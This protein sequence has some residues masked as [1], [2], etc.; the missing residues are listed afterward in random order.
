MFW[1]AMV[2]G[3][4]VSVGSSIGTMSFVILFTGWKCLTETK[5]AKRFNEL[6]ELSCAAL[7]KRN[8]L[9]EKQIGHLATIAAAADRYAEAVE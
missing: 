7:T 1:T 6:S 8:E 9:T 4:G 5:A 3:L 2:W